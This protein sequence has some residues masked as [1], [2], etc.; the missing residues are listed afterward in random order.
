MAYA[1]GKEEVVKP[2]SQRKSALKSLGLWGLYRP[3]YT[4]EQDPYRSAEPGTFR[5]YPVKMRQ[6]V[7]GGNSVFIMVSLPMAPASRVSIAA[8]PD[9]LN[10]AL[11]GFQSY[12]RTPGAEGEIE[13]LTLTRAAQRHRKLGLE[14]TAEGGDGYACAGPFRYGES[15]V[16]VVGRQRIPA[17]RAD[18]TGIGDV[19]IDGARV[20]A[21]RIDHLNGDLSIH[22]LGNDLA[23]APRHLHVF[24]H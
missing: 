1:T 24:I 8:R 6:Y 17:A 20:H 12:L 2:D 22:R 7:A 15:D 13:S 11:K 19:A 10:G 3:R 9:Q 5:H 23:G 18:W 16:A 4:S 21:G 14:L